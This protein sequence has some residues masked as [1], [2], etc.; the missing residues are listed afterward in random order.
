[1]AKN[2][3]FWFSHDPFSPKNEKFF[4]KEVNYLIDLGVQDF[5]KEGNL[6]KAKW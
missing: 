4:P 6:W 2:K 1:M 3:D 5:I